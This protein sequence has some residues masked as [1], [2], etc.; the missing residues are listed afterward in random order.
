M[1]K[2]RRTKIIALVLA[3]VMVIAIPASTYAASS[4][5]TSN[6]TVGF[7]A[8]TLSISSVPTFLFGTTNAI[9]TSSTTIAA[10]TVTG[11]I[12][13]LDDRGNGNG[14]KLTAQLGKFSNA[15]YSGT[16]D[17]MPTAELQLG[18]PTVSPY[19]GTTATAPSTIA[20]A[21]L[22]PGEG[23]AHNII[24]AAVGQGNGGWQGAYATSGVNLKVNPDNVIS[25]SNIATIT[26]TLYDV[27]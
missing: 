17:I 1:S 24:D 21:N 5:L 8:G 22:T 4:S 26:W 2:K 27:P 10:Q 20:A 11:N 12:L 7:S 23:S 6:A 18:A 25:G 15:G 14:W 19:S 9:P 3:L 16:D 13:I